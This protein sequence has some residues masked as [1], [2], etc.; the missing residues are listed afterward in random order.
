MKGLI[1]TDR[2][3]CMCVCMFIYVCVYECVSAYTFF[4]SN[5]TKTFV[6]AWGC[7]KTGK[8]LSHTLLHFAH[9]SSCVCEPIYRVC[10]QVC[11]QDKYIFIYAGMCAH[12]H[13]NVLYL[14][15]V[16]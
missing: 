11:V 6:K 3:W 4:F 7:E 16:S 2:K 10:V 8:P 13:T 9:P 1:E 15:T 14:C 5:L 12:P